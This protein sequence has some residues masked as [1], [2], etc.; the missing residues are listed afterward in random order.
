MVKEVLVG[1]ITHYFNNISVA[2]IEVSKPLKVGDTIQIKGA[3]TDVT[4]KV[5]SM[6]VE[7]KSIKEAKKGDDIGMKVKGL[8]R[9][10]DAVF[11]VG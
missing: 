10:G 7:H 1:K 9:V 11:K 8:V 2:V 5:D 4:Q 6:Q 3:T